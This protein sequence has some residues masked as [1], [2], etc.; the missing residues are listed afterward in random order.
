[1]DED[2]ILR[3][4]RGDSD[5]DDE[6]HDDTSVDED[7]ILREKRGDSDDDSGG[8]DSGGE[9]EPIGA[10]DAEDD[11][12]AAD[13]SGVAPDEALSKKRGAQIVGNDAGG[14]KRRVSTRIVLPIPSV[15]DLP[16]P[17]S[18]ILYRL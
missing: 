4:K 7:V 3:E 5:K 9:H 11:E 18:N 8:D 1:M 6:D 16:L 15:T 17:I 12:D 13:E 14:K 2:A 10:G